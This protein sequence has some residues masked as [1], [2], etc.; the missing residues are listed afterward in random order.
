MPEKSH[1]PTPSTAWAYMYQLSAAL[2]FAQF[3]TFAVSNNRHSYLYRIFSHACRTV[4][5]LASISR[6]NSPVAAAAAAAAEQ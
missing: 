5:F 1:R 2:H 4:V 3:E 6:C